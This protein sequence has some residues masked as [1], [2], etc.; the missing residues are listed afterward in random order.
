MAAVI[1]FPMQRLKDRRGE[2]NFGPAQVIIFN[3]VR[4]ERL[5]DAGGV[6]PLRNRR[7]PSRQN[8][9]TAEDLE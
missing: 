3:G 5:T 1:M 7:L 4:H 8:Q 9:A 2:K 6:A